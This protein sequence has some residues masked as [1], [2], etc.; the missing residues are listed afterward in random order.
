MCRLYGLRAN[1]ATKV[2]C[3]LV[4]AQNA[5]LLQSRGDLRGLDHPDGWGI[6][7]YEDGTPVVERRATA[8]HA[9]LHFSVT[10]ERVFSPTVIAH[11][12]RATV[13][14]PVLN[15]TH[16]FAHG[17]WTFAH[18]G[19][20]TGFGELA[21][22]ME[23]EIPGDLLRY[24]LGSTDSELAFYWLLARLQRAGVRGGAHDSGT[25]ALVQVVARSVRELASWCEA[26]APAE[27]PKLNF[28]LTDG[29]TLVA[30]R[31]N[32]SLSWVQRRGVHDCEIC[33][34][35]HVHHHP[36]VPY[37]AVVVAS[38]AISHEDWQEVPNHSIL[39]TNGSI[40]T[41]IRSL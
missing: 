17:A 22:R 6:G 11:V 24:R 41:S 37:R 3:T 28:L 32:N 16:P 21:G 25:A 26:A 2:E 38:E 8:A 23:R 27:T 34:I 33:G 39:F 7:V 4:R 19:T 15:N 29:H 18:N 30:T 1:E 12:R 35:P 13:G 10:A 40:E 5:L 14:I 31:W 20:V 36:E 9:D